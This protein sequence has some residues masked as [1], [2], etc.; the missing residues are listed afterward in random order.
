MFRRH[1]VI[2]WFMGI[3]SE[4]QWILAID[5]DMGV[6]NADHCIEGYISY[7]QSWPEI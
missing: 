7:N 3:H 6:V 1:C 5:A 2:A 4:L